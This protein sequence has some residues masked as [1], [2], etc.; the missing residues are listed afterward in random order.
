VSRGQRN[1]SPTVVNFRFS[2]HTRGPNIYP[3]NSLVSHW[4]VSSIVNAIR[5]RVLFLVLPYLI[6]TYSGLRDW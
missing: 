2:T 6:V 4:P 5:A 3:V 1:D